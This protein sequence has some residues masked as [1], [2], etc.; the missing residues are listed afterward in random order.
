MGD[1][2]FLPSQAQVVVS[3]VLFQRIEFLFNFAP[4]LIMGGHLW[5]VSAIRPNLPFE[6][7]KLTLKILV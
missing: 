3:S 4:I 1:E 2:G 5:L 6:S 7:H